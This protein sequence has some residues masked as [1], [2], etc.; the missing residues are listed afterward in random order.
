MTN[1]NNRI[2]LKFLI[3]L[4]LSVMLSSCG[5]GGGGSENSPTETSN[6]EFIKKAQAVT[7][8]EVNLYE[9]YVS[10]GDRNIVELNT[11]NL[12]SGELI[13]I[14]VAF[15]VTGDFDDYS[16]SVQLVPEAIISELG[17]G[18][19]MGELTGDRAFTLKLNGVI[20]LGD[21]Y[22]NTVNP[23]LM[24]VIVHGKLPI[25]QENE[26]YKVVVTPSIAYL[27]AGKEFSNEDA[28][29]TPVFIDERILNVNKLE[30]V[31]VKIIDIPSLE[32]NNE[33]SHLEIGS[34]YDAEGYAIDPVFQTHVNLDLTTFNTAE[35]ISLV[36]NWKHPSGIDWP[37]GLLS[38]DA[39]GDPVI[40]NKARFVIKSTDASF[41]TIP[42]V[43]YAPVKTQ[44]ELIKTA[45]NIK[46]IAN[47]N[48]LMGEFSLEVFYEE[49]GND[50]SAGSPYQLTIPLVRQDN[51]AISVDSQ[52]VIGFSLLRAGDT[53][54]ACLSTKPLIDADTFSVGSKPTI[55][56]T[57]C[58]DFPDDRFLW[59][60]DIATSQYIHK[61]TD[62]NGNNLCITAFQFN[63][64]GFSVPE[65][66]RLEAC[67]FNTNSSQSAITIQRFIS[68]DKKIRM[69]F[70]PVY[71]DV[72]FSAAQ[73]KDV[74]MITDA[75][76]AADFETFSIDTNGR[77]FY[78]GHFVDRTWGDEDK[79]A[80]KLSYGGEAYADY[81][82]VIGVTTQGHAKFTAFILGESADIFN[83][84]FVAKK[85]LSK[86][87]SFAGEN[88]P[89]VEVENGVTLKIDTVGGFR[90]INLGSLNKKVISERYSIGDAASLVL[91]DVPDIEPIILEIEPKK[92]NYPLVKIN[93]TVVVIPVSIESGIKGDVAFKVKLTTPGVGLNVAVVDDFT[94][95]GYLKAETNIWIGSVSLDATI[96]ILTQKLEF[97]TKGGFSADLPPATTT[98][99]F[100]MDTSLDATLK[101][102]RGTVVA[103]YEYDVFLKS[104]S[105]MYTIYDSGYL[106][107]NTWK[108]YDELKNSTK[109]EH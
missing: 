9:G 44:N 60:Y 65:N 17:E 90:S 70:L 30:S 67:A 87:I 12:E 54:N 63:G 58:P 59:R 38:S 71:L 81:L 86:K 50:V 24:N 79:A 52:E 82:P 72:I 46:D 48:A 76:L 53:N 105:G 77:I 41:A 22:I 34:K 4:S 109:I 7:F 32:D 64:G 97:I 43:A 55:F 85:H 31:A 69:E 51:R 66:F 108:I 29:L 23:G 91:P 35:N 19:T 56:A 36:L 95:S 39:N 14:D 100:D 103:E 83:A 1:I 96:D 75:V 18:D 102:L 20:N 74:R 78:V 28:N 21:A 10:L 68:E 101:M 5:G 47:K 40:S 88:S 107:Q 11:D 73:F 94:L 3:F 62:D 93:F 98:L 16:L 25:L 33:F 57:N 61:V 92:I 42:V 13:S 104:G 27:S 80:V 26:K 49:N 99:S 106:F 45:I 15:E 8:S 6:P 2:P 84:K 89:D 37:V